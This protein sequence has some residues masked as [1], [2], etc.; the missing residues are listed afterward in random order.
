MD[1]PSASRRDPAIKSKARAPE[2]YLIHD[3]P[4]ILIVAEGC[5]KTFNH[6]FFMAANGTKDSVF[7]T[8]STI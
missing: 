2:L 5:F 8:R 3:N 6:F 1:K 4:T 7:Y